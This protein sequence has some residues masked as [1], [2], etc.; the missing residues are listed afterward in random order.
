MRNRLL[1]L[2]WGVGAMV[3]GSWALAEQAEETPPPTA[4]GTS[5]RNPGSAA[6]E[7]LIRDWPEVPREVAQKMVQK[8]GPPHEATPSLLVW[9]NTGPWKRSILYREEVKHN[10]PKPHTDVLEQFIDYRVPLDRFDEI[11]KFDGSVIAERT[12][13]ELSAR[14]DKEEMN[15]LA[16]NLAN[17]VASGRR[18]V[19]EARTFYTK[20]AMAAMKGEMSPYVQGFQFSLPKGGTADADMPAIKDMAKSL[21]Q[22]RTPPPTR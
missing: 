5:A 10:W 3:G 21:R 16:V 4:P 2:L 22:G 1:G 11:V 8:Y 9:N 18:S 7:Q 13:G 20:T 6:Y 14:C 15:F 17:D 12:K 19:E